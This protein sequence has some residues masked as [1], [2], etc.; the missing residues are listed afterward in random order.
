[1]QVTLV[2]QSGLSSGQTTNVLWPWKGGIQNY[3]SHFIGIYHVCYPSVSNIQSS[4]KDQFQFNSGQRFMMGSQCESPTLGNGKW[5]IW[6][7]AANSGGGAWVATAVPCQILTTA[8]VWHTIVWVTHRDPIGSTNCSGQPCMYY[9]SLTVD[10]TVYTGFPA[11]PSFPNSEGDNSGIQTQLDVSAAGGS[12]TEVLD[13]FSFTESSTAWAS[14]LSPS[15][16]IDFS[17]AGAAH[18]NDARTQCVTT[19]CATVTG[20]T[21][22]AASINAA[23]VSAPA[24]TYVLLPAGSFAPTG[25]IIGK[26]NVTL[27][28]AGAASTFLVPTGSSGS[29]NC[30]NTQI[31]AGPVDNNYAGG[32]SNTATWTGTNGVSGTYTQAATSI[33]LSSK[34]NLA[35]GNPIILDQIDDQSDT[36]NLYA[37]CEIGGNTTGGDHSAACY[38]GAGP[39]GF[40]RGSTA[41]GTIRGQQQI[42]NVTSITGTGP[43]TIG[44]TPGIYAP[45]WRTSQTPGAWWPT[46]PVQNFGVENLSMDVTST[47]AYPITLYNCTGCWVKGV[48]TVTN[49]SGGQNWAHV[50]L[51]VCNHCTVRDSYHFGNIGDDYGYSVFVGSDDLFENNIGQFPAEAFF[52]NSDCEGSVATYNFSSNPYYGASANWLSQGDEFHGVQLYTLEEGNIGA[53]LYADSFHGTHVFNNQFRNRW[54]GHQQNNGQPTSSN[55]IALRL[56]PGTRYN[57]AIGNIFGTCTAGSMVACTA[58]Y[59]TSYKSLS[60]A[61]SIYNSVI[62]SGAYPETGTQDA[63]V[64]TTSMFWGNWDVVSKAARF[65]GSGTLPS[66]CGG[67]SEVPYTGLPSA[68][69]ENPVPASTSLPPSFIYSAK[70]SWWPAGIPWPNIGPDVTGGTEGQCSGGVADGAEVTQSSQCGTGTFIPDAMVYPNAA[71]LCYYGMGG[72]ALGT[73]AALNGFTS[74]TSGCGYL[75]VD[76]GLPQANLSV[77]TLTFA[78]QLAGTTSATQAVTL[79]NGG[80]STLVISGIAETNAGIFIPSDNCPSNLA[81][82]AQCQ[83]TVK[84]A[85]TYPAPQSATIS[86]ESNAASSPNVITITGLG[87]CNGMCLGGPH[88]KRQLNTFGA[89]LNSSAPGYSH[90]LSILTGNTA[91][92]YDT[93]ATYA[94]PASCVGSCTAG[95][96]TFM[97]QGSSFPIM[98]F[99]SFD[100]MVDLTASYGR[101]NNIILYTSSYNGGGGGNSM[102]PAYIFSQA[103]ADK[104]AL[105]GVT[106]NPILTRQNSAYY[107]PSDYIYIAS[108]AQ[109]WRMTQT[110]CSNPRGDG[111]THDIE[112]KTGTSQP[113]CFTNA[114]GG[115][116]TSPCT[117]GTGVNAAV[118]TLTASSGLHAPPLDGFCGAS[119]S[120]PQCNSLPVLSVSAISG[121]SATFTTN[122]VPYYPTGTAIVTNITT[123]GFSDYTCASGCTVTGVGTNTVTIS[124]LSG[125]DA[126]GSVAGTM[127]GDMAINI[128]SPNSPTTAVLATTLPV[129]W[130]LPRRVW[131]N[132]LFQQMALHYANSI[133]YLGMG[134]T[135]GGESSQDCTIACPF[136]SANEYLSYEKIEYQFEGANGVG[137]SFAGRGNLNTNPNVEATYMFANN[138]GPD[139]NAL[140]ANWLF[141][142]GCNGGV[143]PNGDLYHGGNFLLL[144]TTVWNSPMP[145]GQYGV[146][147]VQTSQDSTPGS[148]PGAC[149]IGGNAAGLGSCSQS[150]CSCSTGGTV[151]AMS[152]DASC[153]NPPAFPAPNGYP[154][155]LPA[156]QPY[157]NNVEEYFCDTALAED[158]TY[159]LPTGICP[160]SYPQATWQAPYKAAQQT[161][162]GASTGTAPVFTSAPLATFTVNLAANCPSINCFAV[163]ATGSPTPTFTLTGGTLPSGVTFVDNGNGSATLSGDPTVAAITTLQF[164]ATNSAGSANQ[165]FVLTMVGGNTQGCAPNSGCTS[166]NFTFSFTGGA[167]SLITLPQNWVNNLEYVGTTTNTINFPA[168]LTGGNWICGTTHYGAYTAN[169]LSSLNQAIADAETCRTA[170]GS[171][172][173]INIPPGLFTATSGLLLP[174]TTGDSSNNFIILTSTSPLTIGQ[175]ACSHGIQD[176]LSASTQ[177]GIRNI[178]CAG[179]AMSYQLGQTVT[180]I[181]S[182]AFTLANGTNTNTSAYNDIASLWTIECSATNC[183]AISTASPDGNGVAPHNFALLN[184]EA[185]PQAGLAQPSAIVKIG[186]GT[187]T[188]VLQLPTH[189][190]LGYYYVHGDWADGPPAVGTNV[191]PN[192]IVFN[193]NQCSA[194]YGYID[195]SLRPASEGHGIYLGLAQQIKI[196]HNWVEGQ[197]IGL[198]AGGYSAAIPIT[199][200]LVSDIEDRANRYTYPY[201]W[202]GATAPTQGSY[203]RK[204]AHEFKVGTRIVHDGNIDENVDDSGAQ[205]G[206]VLSWKTD[207]ISSGTGSNF[208]V[209]QNNTTITNNLIR[210]SCNGVSLGS[211]SASGSGNGGGVTLPAQLYNYSNN[212]MQNVSVNN[213]GCGGV[214]TSG[215]QY[216]FRIAGATNTWTATA[217]RDVTG[218]IAILTLTSAAGLT[219]SDQNIGDPVAVLNCADATFNTSPSAMGPLA[220]TGTNPTGLTVVYANAGTPSATTTGCT[221]SNNQG[222][223]ENVIYNHNT[224]ILGTQGQDPYSPTSGG[225]NPFSLSRGLSLA[226]SIIVNGGANSVYAE[227]TRTETKAFDPSTLSFNNLLITGRSAITCPG[228]TGAS[229]YT[230]YPG[231]ISPPTNVYVTPTANCTGSSPTSGC[232][233]F[234]GVM[235]TS[236]IPAF[237]NDWHSWSLVSGST[238]A[239]GNAGQATDGTS[240]G[241][242]PNLID[243]AQTNNQYT[244]SNPCGSGPYADH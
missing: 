124:G 166:G 52:C 153:T 148:T 66:Y 77:T 73:G 75:S 39:N 183:D 112:C 214:G 129:P 218:T 185:R 96:A 157:T 100:P 210:S 234:T 238:Y 115:K 143:P 225:T 170:N 201:A 142:I 117:D 35:V 145:N 206:L 16:A 138:V 91:G 29:S 133:G 48:R 208:W 209:A 121:G 101:I 30:N 140:Q 11:E 57:N 213:P 136:E 182:G 180:P 88:P 70:P 37:G 82:G 55:T 92:Q 44:I 191:I 51:A 116:G 156:M 45:N 188:A 25:Q 78:A 80:S 187:E 85:P 149:Y 69:Y 243:S 49:V 63:L 95:N 196:N 98:N 178:G 65:C 152:A 162:I 33:I 228:F 151:G 5:D 235:S 125:S 74:T 215:P 202:L 6:N 72:T 146:I 171:G 127:S 175:T 244:C 160:T 224:N 242:A 13:E 174:Q 81:A 14:V 17:Q 64:N 164:T 168:T 40:E 158:S 155:N 23:I 137:T 50:Q 79:S 223:T 22:T 27:R 108:S 2:G 184:F 167:T 131:Q 189:I 197:S 176:N 198:F 216:G 173:T 118:W 114:A 10:G 122:T 20:G 90:Y 212:L 199:N 217:S 204:N 194:M 177:P 59:H 68:L 200:F 236:S 12:A 58:A 99:S 132:T 154:G 106:M 193:C 97:D 4:E 24:N 38:Q 226:N 60:T 141:S 7:Q 46:S 32:P 8:A 103:W 120:V 181:S 169:S 237:L 110:T 9:D 172:T 230:Q 94:L 36:G 203:V 93:G 109:Y 207:N 165:A 119:Y 71:M 239:A 18:I 190:H 89:P 15:R 31:C 241:F 179:T 111:D 147:T 195:K 104:L 134:L 163:T 21:V 62:D 222:W 47:N 161:Y 3:A 19:A 139:N 135:K 227:G 186:L 54:D 28:G 240:L 219:Q 86:V 56:N 102:V 43:Y 34:T 211:R 144:A 76:S 220:L 113:A 42:V 87:T 192:D 107:P 105:D 41:L 61:T 159:P 231:T 232:A 83:I 123:G 205:G 150:S 1:M 128:N 67:L 229:C 130:E 53:G 233:G 84:F 26:S 126:G 221:F